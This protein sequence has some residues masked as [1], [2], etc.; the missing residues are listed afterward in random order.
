MGGSRQEPH[1]AS[2]RGCGHQGPLGSAVVF[3]QAGM[4]YGRDA[5]TA[6]YTFGNPSLETTLKAVWE[7]RI[8]LCKPFN[9]GRVHSL[10]ADLILAN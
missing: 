5:D 9:G 6:Q 4:P 1:G 10:W 3:P 2:T 7:Q 8:F